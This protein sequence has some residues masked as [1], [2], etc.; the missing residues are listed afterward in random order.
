MAQRA[1]VFHLDHASGARRKALEQGNLEERVERGNPCCQC[2]VGDDSRG[3][4]HTGDEDVNGAQLIG[5]Q[6]CGNKLAAVAQIPGR[7]TPPAADF[8]G[9]TGSGRTTAM[10]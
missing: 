2:V 9:P 1:D 8:R 10:E 3:E 5:E 6:S 4:Q 7:P